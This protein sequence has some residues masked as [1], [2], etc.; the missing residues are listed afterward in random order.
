MDL[1]D[2]IIALLATAL[3]IYVVGLSLI[4]AFFA[5]RR[6]HFNQTLTDISKGETVS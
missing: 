1:G 5:A 6:R 3:V 4:A 2:Y